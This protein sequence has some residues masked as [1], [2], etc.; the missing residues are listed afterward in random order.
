MEFAASYVICKL[1]GNITKRE[2][3]LPDEVALSYLSE[4]SMREATSFVR[5]K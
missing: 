1:A 4:P 2:A 5:I 3:R